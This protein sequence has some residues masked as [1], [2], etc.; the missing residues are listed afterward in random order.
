MLEIQKAAGGETPAGRSEGFLALS[1]S[2]SARD[3]FAD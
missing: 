1:L 2:S 3:T